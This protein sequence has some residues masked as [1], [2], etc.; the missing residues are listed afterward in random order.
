MAIQ[1]DECR[2]TPDRKPRQDPV[3]IPDGRS[4][5]AEEI[6]IIGVPLYPDARARE[7]PIEDLEDYRSGRRLSHKGMASYKSHKSAASTSWPR[8]CSRVSRQSTAWPE[9]FDLPRKVSLCVPD[10]NRSAAGICA[11]ASTTRRSATRFAGS[12]ALHKHE[13]RLT[14]PEIL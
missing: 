5:I 14:Q 7:R 3:L 1:A 8:G 13:P 6:K 11:T 10:K 4:S 2:A 12:S 9:R